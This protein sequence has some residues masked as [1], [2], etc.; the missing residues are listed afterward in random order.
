MR[1]CLPFSTGGAAIHELLHYSCHQH[2]NLDNSMMIISTRETLN[3]DESVDQ[4]AEKEM[5][6]RMKIILAGFSEVC[7]M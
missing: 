1:A 2:S 4:L 5:I 6:Q 7:L 3:Y